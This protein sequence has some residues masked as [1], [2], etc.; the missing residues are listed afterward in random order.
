VTPD[1][2]RGVFVTG[3]DTGVGKTIVACALLRALAAA[4][5]RAVG[6]KPVAAGFAPGS[7]TNGDVLALAA[8][9]NVDAPQAERNPYAFADP[10]AP[11]LAADAA[12]VTLDLAAIGAAYAR[13]R[14]RA[15]AVV[16]EGAGGALVPLSARHDML[17]VAASLGLPVLLVVGMRLGCQSHA[18]MSALVIR[19]RGLVLAGWVANELPPGM[20]LLARNVEEIGR[21]IGVAPLAVVR[22]SEPPRIGADAL[23]L[24]G[25][26]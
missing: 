9:S 26:A 11:Q 15:G 4:G 18:L 2:T 24:L 21:R 12:G 13:L 1:E 14:A 10:V 8:A 3:T 17:D 5:L 20:P 16:V 23:A 25:F 7:G 6:M 19:A 22:A